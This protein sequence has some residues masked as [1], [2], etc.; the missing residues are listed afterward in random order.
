MGQTG[1]FGGEVESHWLAN[2]QETAL[3]KKS[4]RDEGSAARF[5][6]HTDRTLRYR[7]PH[8]GIGSCGRCSSTMRTVSCGL[9]CKRTRRT[10]VSCER[11]LRI[12][13]LL[14]REVFNIFRWTDAEVANGKSIAAVVRDHC[15]AALRL[16]T[17]SSTW[18]RRRHTPPAVPVIS[19]L[20][21]IR[22]ID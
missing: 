14:R 18:Q 15:A 21:G 17:R 8:P 11:A 6:R 20:P 3:T 16:P 13:N 12:G 9:R 19:G 22:A 7:A 2:E 10:P 4:R 5:N 1:E